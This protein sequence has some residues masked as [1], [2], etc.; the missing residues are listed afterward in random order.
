MSP[1][2]V[3]PLFSWTVEEKVMIV[4]GEM[5]NKPEE[6]SKKKL[7]RL[8]EEYTKYKKSYLINFMFDPQQPGLSK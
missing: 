6:K 7:Q 5:T 3:E 4:S 1:N 2:S 8:I